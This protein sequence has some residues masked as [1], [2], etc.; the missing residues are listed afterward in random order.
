M[1]SLNKKK[2]RNGAMP[3]FGDGSP[4]LSPLAQCRA[5]E[6]Q[7]GFQ[8]RFA[9]PR[10]HRDQTQATA[11]F[12]MPIISKPQKLQQDMISLSPIP[13]SIF[14]LSHQWSVCHIHSPGS[15]APAANIYLK[16]HSLCWEML[17]AV[18]GAASSSTSFLVLWPHLQ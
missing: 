17:S 8:A 11:S 3:G 7:S 1:S 13:F 4:P 10:E 14:L 2:R 6:P 5:W 18:P 16:S 15:T 9:L 12:S